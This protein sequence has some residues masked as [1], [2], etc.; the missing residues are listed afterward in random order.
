MRSDISKVLVERQR[1]GSKDKSKKTGLKIN[2]NL[3]TYDDYDFGPNHLPSSRHEKQLNENLR[4]LRQ[5]LKKSVGRKW[6]DVY[7]EIRSCI[8]PRKAI[9]F[10][11]LQHLT[12]EVNI[13][14]TMI[15]GKP[16]ILK[17]GYSTPCERLYVNPENGLLEE[18]TKIPYRS[19]SQKKEVEQVWYSGNFWFKKEIKKRKSVCGCVHFKYPEEKYQTKKWRYKDF[20]EVCIHGNCAI[21]EIY[22]YLIEYG[23]HK[24]TDVYKIV[25]W[26][27]FGAIKYNL[28][29]GEQHTIYY[30][31]VPHKLEESFEISRKTPNKKELKALRMALKKDSEV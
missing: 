25:N 29:E 11:V 26:N 9:G 3:E 30:A 13:E 2:P 28:K 22:W 8:D 31:D 7:S 21:P 1:I 18:G 19:F 24:P 27:D 5:F 10:H 20:P 15:N 17:Y 14:V 16:F 23:W 4:P 6:D 12:Y